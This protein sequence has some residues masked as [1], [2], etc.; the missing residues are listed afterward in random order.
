MRRTQIILTILICGIALILELRT[1]KQFAL[2]F[3]WINSVP[4]VGLSILSFL[5]LILNTR[6]YIKNRL[7][8]SF[9]PM[10]VSLISLFVVIYSLKSRVKQ[11]NSKTLFKATTNSIGNDGGLIFDFKKNG[12]LKVERR[13]HWVVTYYWGKYY[14][15]KDTVFL[16]ISLDFKL[17]KKALLN[18]SSLIFIKDNFTFDLYIDSNINNH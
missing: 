15:Q 11:D 8:I 12:H 2:F 17:E 4:L 16:D 9:L 1:T 14:T 10:F 18:D 7:V 3:D 13:D 5:F 6:N